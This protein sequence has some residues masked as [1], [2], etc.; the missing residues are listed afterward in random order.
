MKTKLLFLFTILSLFVLTTHSQVIT[1]NKSSIYI[2]NKLKGDKNQ[3]PPTIT[4]ISPDIVREANLVIN[5]NVLNIL[6]KVTAGNGINSIYINQRRIKTPDDDFFTAEI[7]LK[8]GRND[9]SMILVDSMYFFVEKKFTVILNPENITTDMEDINTEGNYYCLIIG[10][11][12]YFDPVIPNIN[13]PLRDANNL[14][15]TLTD[16]YTFRKDNVSFIKNPTK[17]ELIEALENLTDNVTEND[18]LLI[19][20][21]GHGWWD[22]ETG[23]GYW[24]PSDAVAQRKE[25]WIPNSTICAFLKEVNLKHILLIADAGFGGDIFNPR[26]IFKQFPEK[27]EKPYELPGRKVIT[28]GL[29]TEISEKSAFMNLLIKRLLINEEK[30]LSSYHLFYDLREKVINTGKIIPQYGEI[31]STGDEDGDFVFIKK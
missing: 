26:K 31:M 10:I 7:T 11:N 18:N 5:K 15:R 16:N 6:G 19:F 22:N 12:E 14:Y 9:I 25:T 21:S 30:Y 27:I 28:S 3:A 8:P 29:S 23:T 24:L 4:L 13:I 1:S 2:N 17:T 20:Y